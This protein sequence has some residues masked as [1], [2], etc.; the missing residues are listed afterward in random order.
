M[1]AVS[2]L[3]P[4]MQAQQ[5]PSQPSI[6]MPGMSFSFMAN[7]ATLQQ[8]QQQIA[9]GLRVQGSL[10]HGFPGGMV[11]HEGH[12]GGL[13]GIDPLARMGSS[14]LGMVAGIP[15]AGP[16]CWLPPSTLDTSQDHMRRP[17]AA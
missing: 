17:P 7:P 2:G 3:D 16:G 15:I 14:A 1:Q 12:L 10:G 9:A 4:R 5:Q 11:K 8:Q 6:D 13:G